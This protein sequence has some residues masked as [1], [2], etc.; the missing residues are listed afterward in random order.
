M[1]LHLLPRR[2][3]MA[4]GLAQSPQ[5]GDQLGLQHAHPGARCRNVAELAGQFG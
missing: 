1:L 5:Q 2:P 4:Q 3:L